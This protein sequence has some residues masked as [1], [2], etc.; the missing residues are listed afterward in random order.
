MPFRKSCRIT[1]TDE[2][3]RPVAMFYT[4]SIGKNTLHCRPMS[5]YFHGYYRQERRAVAGKNYE[6]LSVH[7]RGHYVGTVLNVIQAAVG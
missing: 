7:G 3:N 2:G 4:M 5:P 1:A 6:F